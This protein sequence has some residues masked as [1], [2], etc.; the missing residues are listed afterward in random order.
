MDVLTDSLSTAINRQ[1][2]F[3]STRTALIEK[4]LSHSIDE[5]P[6]AYSEL[7]QR[8]HR[9]LDAVISMIKDGKQPIVRSNEDFR[10]AYAHGDCALLARGFLNLGLDVKLLQ[11]QGCTKH[12]TGILNV[13]D[14]PYYVDS[15]GVFPS[16]MPIT[17]RYINDSIDCSLTF[18]EDF[19]SD[20]LANQTMDFWDDLEGAL[21]DKLNDVEEVSQADVSDYEDY[22]CVLLTRTLLTLLIEDN[23]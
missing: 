21:E 12:W 13:D 20:V 16:L 3:N 6:T 18:D 17:A 11:E 8:A 23:Q 19:H 1:N 9:D 10:Y 5:L 4:A 2:F 14:R 15:Y 7:M 22:V